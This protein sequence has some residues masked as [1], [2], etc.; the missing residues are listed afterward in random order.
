LTNYVY[1]QAGRLSGITSPLGNYYFGYD[2]LGNRYTLTKDGQT[3]TYTL[4]QAAGLTTVLREGTTNYLYGL[5]LIGQETGGE[6][7]VA[8]ADRL[9]SVRQLITED[10]SQTLLQS[11]DPFGNPLTSVGEGES[12]F[13]YTGEQTDG[14]GLVYL[15]AR[16]MDPQ[17]GRF[18]TPDPFPGVLSLPVLQ[19]AYP[20]AANN[21]LIFTDPSG[22]IIPILLAAVGATVA[23][24]IISGGLNL[25]SQCIGYSNF[26]ECTKCA[27]WTAVGAAAGAGALAG[28]FG[29]GVGLIAIPTG[30]GMGMAMFG[31]F[32]VGMASGQVFKI[33]ELSLLGR[34]DQIPNE[35]GHIDDM[36]VDGFIGSLGSAVGYGLFQH[37]HPPK[38]TS[39]EI[40][41]A[42]EQLAAEKLPIDLGKKFVHL[43]GRNRI[44]DGT[45]RVGSKNYVEI[46]TSTKGVVYAT[47]FI[48]SQT[49]FDYNYLKQSGN[50][51][52]WIFVKSRP[53]GPLADLLIGYGIHFLSS[54]E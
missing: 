51:P 4:D 44:Y 22:E 11:F 10:R 33:A 15:R 47:K 35:L 5:G 41:R 38:L 46:K 1:D 53:S 20:Y 9:G 48:R 24:G 50:S 29:F 39:Q 34:Q 28:L 7:T 6:T 14:S 23:G 52:L 42:A 19:N 31:G 17:T 40:G 32:L 43:P 16:Y 18:I 37:L 36:L 27:D 21:P 2:G 12:G 3:T 13:G 49:L 45:L 26:E 30:M 8:L 54:W 25:L